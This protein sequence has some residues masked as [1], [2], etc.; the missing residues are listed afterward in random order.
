MTTN[1]GRQTS[2]RVFPCPKKRKKENVSCLKCNKTF[3]GIPGVI[4]ICEKCKAAASR[5]DVCEPTMY[6]VIGTPI[7]MGL[8]HL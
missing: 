7:G 2:E 4:R 8:G 6:H 5:S 3:K 1:Y